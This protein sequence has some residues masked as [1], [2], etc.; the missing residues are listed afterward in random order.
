M[1]SVEVLMRVSM[2]SLVLGGH[3]RVEPKNQGKSDDFPAVTTPAEAFMPTLTETPKVELPKVQPVTAPQELSV[4]LSRTPEIKTYSLNATSRFNRFASV[5]TGPNGQ[6]LFIRLTPGDPSFGIS[7]ADMP[8]FGGEWTP[9]SYTQ[10]VLWFNI[11]KSLRWQPSEDKTYCNIF[12]WDVTRALGV[13]IPH[14]VDGNETNANWIYDWL[15]GEGQAS[16]Y[17]SWRGGKG[18]DVGWF[19]VTSKEAGERANQGYPT[20]VVASDNREGQHGHAAIVV[21]GNSLVSSGIFYPPVAQAGGIISTNVS[22]YS[23]FFEWYSGRVPGKYPKDTKPR[24]FSIDRKYNLTH[25]GDGLQLDS[26]SDSTFV[27]TP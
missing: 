17:P 23:A 9:D 11:L 6:R 20:V 15:T 12:V 19:E 8:P 10:S 25:N 13:E 16:G 27:E 24:Y 5:E 4:V 7:P 21:P 2:I 18:S 3:S 22:S 14:Y 26:F 1:R